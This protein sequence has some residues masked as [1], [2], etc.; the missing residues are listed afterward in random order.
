MGVS[1]STYIKL[2][3]HRIGL[4]FSRFFNDLG[5][6]TPSGIVSDIYL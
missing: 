6:G 5:E 2:F 1:F 3:F 4:I